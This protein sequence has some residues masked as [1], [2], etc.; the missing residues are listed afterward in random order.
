M[1]VFFLFA[2]FAFAALSID[3]GKLYVVKKKLQNA[4]DS[5]AHAGAV[6]CFRKAPSLRTERTI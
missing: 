3:V 2:L 4:T 1:V 5:G 6:T